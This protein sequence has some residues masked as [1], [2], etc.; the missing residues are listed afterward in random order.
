[1]WVV[2]VLLV[3]AACW[4]AVARPDW[5]DCP[6]AGCK[7]VWTSGKK[8]AFCL[9]AGFKAV[10]DSLDSDMQVLDLSGNDIP[11]LTEDAFKSVGLLNLQK[12]YLKSAGIRELHRDAFEDLTILVEV[13]LSDNAIRTLHKDTFSGNDRL[14]LL[15]LNGNPLTEL[16]E[17]QFPVLP[18]L[19]F[20][21]LQNC[22]LET[23]HEDAFVHLTA[24]ESLRLNG[25]KLK[26][27]S[28]AVFV[29]V[30]KLKTLSLDDN[31]WK[32]DCELRSFRDWILSSN[33]YSHPLTCT[34]PTA[35]GA[36]KWE[37]VPATEFACAPTVRVSD[38]RLQGEPGENVTLRCTA[39]GDP[40]PSLAW[41]FNG[42]P[43][44]N[45]SEDRPLFFGG[46]G[47]TSLSIVD[48]TEA[49]AGE[50]T[51]TAE[52][53]RGRA[54]VNVSLILP[55]VVTATTLS[56]SET[57]F[58]WIVWAVASTASV[59]FT[60]VLTCIVCK[61]K[62]NGSKRGRKNKMRAS[63]SFNDQDK[64]LLDAS[65][66]TTDRQTGS[67]EGLGSQMDVEL[68]EHSLQSIPLEVCERPVHIT[69][70]SHRGD[71]GLAVY[72]PPAEFAAGVLPAPGF[73]NIFISVSVSQEPAATGGEPPG[74][75]DLLDLPH[76]KSVSVGAGPDAPYLPTQYD[77]MGPRVTAAGSSTLSLPDSTSGEEIPPPPPPPNCTPVT[78]EYVSL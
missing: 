58:I 23:I 62:R 16:R 21:E 37:E 67:C 30:T 47:W 2:R 64:K 66:T 34:E 10:P 19:K 44:G 68:P 77:N 28:E 53:P 7:C 45:A 20:L 55:E 70:E 31:P 33:L 14:K 36:A 56:K 49:D 27:L 32:C 15:N 18:H 39:S 4:W 13:D 46:E 59:F 48:I 35:L 25:N 8:S 24:L 57:W 22:Q 26:R 11:Y 71:P 43:L 40:E 38:S 76:R 52:N 74:Y 65:I 41:L 42:R 29:P 50:Y 54:A 78:V 60:V 1:M 17:S 72:R 61:I 12:I 5:A 75:P 6:V 63:A 73:G 69:I 3:G 9:K 51:C